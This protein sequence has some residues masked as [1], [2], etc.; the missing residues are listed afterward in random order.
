MFYL[1]IEA[2]FMPHPSWG[3][4][5]RPQGDNVAPGGTD[6]ALKPRMETIS[7]A[8]VT[9]PLVLWETGRRGAWMPQNASVL[10]VMN[11]LEASGK[12]P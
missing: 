11:L 3:V 12:P 4:L 5:A 2:V 8:S 7:L 9:L 10:D 1:P 6:A